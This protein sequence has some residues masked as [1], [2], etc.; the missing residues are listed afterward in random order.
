M[1]VQI[2]PK[3]GKG[4]EDGLF[5]RLGSLVTGKW[6][7]W[8]TLLVW[9]VAVGLLVTLPPSLANLYDNQAGSD[10]GNQESVR[11]SQVLKEKFP[12]S[13]GIPA[14]IV[15]N[16]ATGLR[17]SDFAKAKQVSDW[18]TSAQKPARVES[19]L[20]ITTVP[21]AR[22]ELVSANGTTVEML[23]TIQASD[24][25]TEALS[26][27]VKE[28]RKYL[29]GIKSN[30]LKVSVTGPAGVLADT[31]SIFTSTDLPLLLTTV[32]LVLVLLL[33]VYR[34][35]ILAIMPLVVVGFALTATQGLLSLAVKAG[36]FSVSQQSSSI[37]SVLLFGVGVD[38]TIFLVSRYREELHH[39]FDR[40]AALRV[41]YSRIA[42]AIVSSAS[43]VILALLT[44]LLATLGLYRSLGPTLAVGVA[45]MLLV[46]LTLVPALLAILGRAAFWP[47]VP[48]VEVANALQ[49]RKPRR[50]FWHWLG[51]NVARRPA[52]SLW[53]STLLLFVFGL[54][55]LGVIDVFN[56]L[57]GFRQ[58]TD[59]KEGY[60]VL[61]ANFEPGKLATTDLIL[62][63][64]NGTNAYDQLTALESIRQAVAG[65]NN[66]AE[67]SGPTRLNGQTEDTATLQKEFAA[68][69]GPLKAGLRQGGQGQAGGSPAGGA[70]GRVIG[71]YA[72]T[73]SYIS[74]DNSVVR[75]SVT[76]KSD[77]Y[78][79]AALDT[80]QPLR[81]T[82]RNAS[83]ASGLNAQVLL[84]GVTAQ[85][86]DIREVNN[87]DK[88]IVIPVAVILTTLVLAVLLRS[89]IAPLYL[90][91][92]VL[93]N[94][95]ATVGAASFLF[96]V[97][98]GDEGRAYS[99]P[100]YAFI[101]LVSLGADY[102]IF[103]MTRIREEA[104]RVG[105]EEG[106][107]RAVSSTGGVITS[108]G[109][110][111]AGTFAVLTI[112][113]LREL[114]QL[115]VVV[116]LGVILDTFVV[117]GVVVP[118]TVLLCKQFNWWPSR[119]ESTVAT[120]ISPPVGQSEPLEKAG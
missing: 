40:L 25:D 76:L 46:G 60:N 100:L 114:F 26:N 18:L 34:S 73:L 101:F 106:T 52:A 31:I 92:A 42:E 66:V 28:I 3:S 105:L 15:F 53:V 93:L 90:I 118:G 91:I 6:G 17:D 50:S 85:N 22:D 38:Y 37:L 84:G 45:V 59:S 13:T 2:K 64:P 20:S 113:P 99:I 67:V 94:F 120:K 117:R 35:P 71:L 119:L 95:F 87:R 98:E 56:F 77:P 55:N 103:L 68:L 62:V 44:L 9:I 16:N 11:A 10:I 65:V 80:I 102:T 75:F 70:D 48:K 43:T 12:Q 112:L 116:A 33:I 47:L 32:G 69:P 49:G 96:V 39:N 5:Y 111:L 109:L 27:T 82:T 104:A 8:V 86:A 63:L 61:A 107:V 41:A 7:R 23:A 51:Q 29:D 24:T 4:E 30:D 110:I 58:P 108:A 74:A 89:L 83:Q 57:S 81:D 72:Q 78:G 1:S 97:I 88:L 79:K 19:V 14:I 21:Q 115:G 36:L 54:G